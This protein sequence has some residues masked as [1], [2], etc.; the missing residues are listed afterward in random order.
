L[1][2]TGGSKDR[3]FDIMFE[4]EGAGSFRKCVDLENLSYE[5]KSK[6]ELRFGETHSLQNYYSSLL[7]G[8]KSLEKV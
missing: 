5:L 8:D 3:D 7:I 6:L 1:E 2:A 4:R